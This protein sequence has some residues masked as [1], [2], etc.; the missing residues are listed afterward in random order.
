MRVNGHTSW[1]ASWYRDVRMTLVW[2]LAVTEQGRRIIY[3]AI[4]GL[5]DCVDARGVV[6]AMP[7]TPIAPDAAQLI[8]RE[9]QHFQIFEGVRK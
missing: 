1:Q 8:R 2:M 7:T 6:C 9:I 5:G 4:Q 3:N